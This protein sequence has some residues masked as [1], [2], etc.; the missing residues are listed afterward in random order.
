MIS[1]LLAVSIYC[2]AQ[3]PPGVHAAECTAEYLHT[4]PGGER[5]TSV[6]VTRIIGP[7]TR[8]CWGEGHP[9]KVTMRENGVLVCHNETP[10]FADGFESGDTGEWR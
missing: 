9:F 6:A 3:F 1:L 2:T 4:V 10:L 7:A 5:Y 8:Y